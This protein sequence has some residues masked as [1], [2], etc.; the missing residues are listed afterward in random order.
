MNYLH[1]PSRLADLPVTSPTIMTSPSF[2]LQPYGDQYQSLTNESPPPNFDDLRTPVHH[3]R[4]DWLTRRSH[5]SPGRLY[6]NPSD[7]LSPLRH[8]QK[9]PA[10]PSTERTSAWVEQTQQQSHHPS[11]LPSHCN[12]DDTHEDQE[13]IT[14]PAQ[15]SH[16]ADLPKPKSPR[17]YESPIADKKLS[18]FD[19]KLPAPPP[20]RKP[21]EWVQNTA[22]PPHLTHPSPKSATSPVSLAVSTT[23]SL[24]PLSVTTAKLL[25]RSPLRRPSLSQAPVPASSP[26][27]TTTVSPHLVNPP[28]SPLLHPTTP[29]DEDDLEKPAPMTRSPM[30][31]SLPSSS[32][33]E[34]E[35]QS[36]P[37]AYR[38]P[39]YSSSSYSPTE[40]KLVAAK[41]A[42]PVTVVCSKSTPVSSPLASSSTTIHPSRSVTTAATSPLLYV[43]TRS[44][45][46]RSSPPP[47]PPLSVHRPLP[48]SQPLPTRPPSSSRPSSSS[49][50]VMRMSRLSTQSSS[51]AQRRPMAT[52]VY[53]HPRPARS[54]SPAVRPT[55]SM[56]LVR[57]A[58]LPHYMQTTESY[59][60]RVQSTLEDKPSQ[61]PRSRAG[62]VTRRAP[63][64]HIR[65]TTK[66]NASDEIR[67]EMAPEDDYV[68]LAA[69]V[70]LFEKELGN[71]SNAPSTSY[72]M[73][74]TKPKSPNLLTRAR[75]LSSSHRHA[76]AQLEQQQPEPSR[77]KRPSQ[78]M[79]E[80]TAKRM[81]PNEQRA[82]LQT[83]PFHFN[84]TDRAAR[85]QHLFQAKLN[86]WKAKEK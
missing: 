71:R 41:Q 5:E 35:P 23:S 79:E 31:V 59:V 1:S 18:P 25:A 51:S 12:F 63:V 56:P 86:H 83:K 47:D 27:R 10:S 16:W 6:A 52:P 53:R 48:S 49:Q 74:I 44:P 57:S 15:V 73:M 46:R 7:A 66:I 33:Q 84:T 30:T 69:R 75:S 81:R 38:S 58:G 72:H 42:S 19:V 82:P 67:N 43:S 37:A 29:H 85:Y 80:S 28:T 9:P 26:L 36:S 45:V 39:V 54:H 78:A 68:P 22:S 60:N 61:R 13:N 40:M 62:S 70:K 20:P 2:S 55:S 21:L 11:P 14:T 65:S 76:H 17:A 8:E 4:S 64:P 24:P 3:R 77:F 50:P 34:T 32:H